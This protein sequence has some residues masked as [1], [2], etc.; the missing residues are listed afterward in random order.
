MPI[1]NLRKEN[2]GDDP[3]YAL[4]RRYKLTIA[5]HCKLLKHQNATRDN[6]CDHK[7]LTDRFVHFYYEPLPGIEPSDNFP[8]EEG[9]FYVG[10]DCARK[11][12]D[13]LMDFSGEELE[14][15]PL[16]DPLKSQPREDR[17][18]R[19]GPGTKPSE[20]IEPKAKA[21]PLNREMIDAINLI[22]V[23]TDQPLYI[24][25]SQVADYL[26][27]N[28]DK[29]TALWSV[30]KLNNAIRYHRPFAGKTLRHLINDEI[31]VTTE[32]EWKDYQFIH[33]EAALRR[34]GIE[35]S[36]IDPDCDVPDDLLDFHE[37]TVIEEKTSKK[38]EPY[39][40]VNID[41]H[42]DNRARL[43]KNAITNYGKGP[44]TLGTQLIGS[45][46][47]HEKYGPQVDRDCFIQDRAVYGTVLFY[48][49][50]NGYGFIE[51]EGELPDIHI[52]WPL[53]RDTG[54][55]SLDQGDMV[56]VR[57]QDGKPNPTATFIM[58]VE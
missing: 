2:R 37:F 29:D 7:P 40:I 6:I 30:K 11:I 1:R 20:P 10:Y 38:G 48:H 41:H 23:L 13:H 56:A 35:Q 52:G 45:L 17:G 31:A 28:P 57:Y 14:L 58:L 5:A 32:G 21:S 33:I 4:V 34:M 42:D 22:P 50:E 19:K 49:R 53:L 16:F 36:F 8:A 12:I 24:S 39:W 47:E 15:P 54:L 27:T 18:E 51:T 26:R 55:N 25:L 46:I 43:F 9:S 44:L 3:K